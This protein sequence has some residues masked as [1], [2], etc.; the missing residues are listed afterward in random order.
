MFGCSSS[1]A[2]VDSRRKRSRKRA[3]R[4]SSG[5]RI[6]S[7]TRVPLRTSCA[8]NT[9]PIAP[10]PIIRST[11]KSAISIPAWISVDISRPDWQGAA[12]DSRAGRQLTRAAEGRR[13]LEGLDLGRVE[14]DRVERGLHRRK[15]LNAR[16]QAIPDGRDAPVPADRVVAARLERAVV[17]RVL[18]D[19]GRAQL[20]QDLLALADAMLELDPV[21]VGVAGREDLS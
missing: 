20:Q 16:D 13:E 18:L 3:S 11:R 6:F 15:V 10:A 17:G 19:A 21:A 7:A 14:P 1:A 4:A 9:L 12:A 8:R 5:T 2:I